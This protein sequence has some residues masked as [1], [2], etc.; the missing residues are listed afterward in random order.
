MENEPNLTMLQGMVDHLI[1]EDDECKGVVT[2]T[3]QIIARSL[4]F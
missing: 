1:V 3:V 4:L 2:Q